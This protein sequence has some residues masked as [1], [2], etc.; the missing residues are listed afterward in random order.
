M[1]TRQ[2]LLVGEMICLLPRYGRFAGMNMILLRLNRQVILEVVMRRLRRTGL[3]AL[4][5]ILI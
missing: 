3:K 5:T 4:F 2:W 1:A